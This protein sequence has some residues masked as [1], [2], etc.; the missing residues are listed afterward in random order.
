[1]HPAVAPLSSGVAL[2]VLG[3]PLRDSR[4]SHH[5]GA[6]VGGGGIGRGDEFGDRNL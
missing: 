3:E 1:M 4:S 2:D 6:D 5:L